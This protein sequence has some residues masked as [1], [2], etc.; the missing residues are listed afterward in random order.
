MFSG[1]CIWAVGSAVINQ[2][3]INKITERTRQITLKPNNYNNNMLRQ[4][5]LR[6][7]IESVG[8]WITL[9]YILQPVLMQVQAIPRHNFAYALPPGPPMPPTQ[10]TWV[11]KMPANPRGYNQYAFPNQGGMQGPKH[12]IQYA[13]PVLPQSNHGG[14][15]PSNFAMAPYHGDTY[16]VQ[17]GQMNNN[18]ST[19]NPIK[20][21]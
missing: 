16:K 7:A 20:E 21:A 4:I 5:N 14:Y 13:Q 9:E 19:E 11:T 10:Q 2:L 12:A 8:D 6:L 18:G 15:Q 17:P 3:Y 1:C